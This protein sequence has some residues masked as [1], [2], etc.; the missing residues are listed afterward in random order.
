MKFNLNTAKLFVPDGLPDDKA[1]ARTT[2]MAIGA[3]P[4]D[5]E[6]MAFHG[7]LECFH[8]QKKWLTGVTVTNGSGS[9]RDGVYS[10]YTD[11]EMRA[12]RIKEQKKAAIVGE[13]AA[14]AFLDYP[15]SAVKD[16]DNKGPVNDIIELLKAAQP[17]VLFTHNLADKH[18]THVAVALRVIE[19]ARSLPADQ[20]PSRVFGCE[21]WR[22]LDWMCDK[23]KVAFECSRHENLQMALLG[24][25]DSQIAGGKRYDLATMGR[26]RAHATYH[27]AHSVDIM[28]GTT[29]AMD[30]TPL[31][32]DPSRDI[33][34][35]IKGFIDRFSE[36]V[37][38]SITKL[39]SK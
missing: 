4:D 2:H 17:E 33:A 22:D 16:P 25:F 14:H 13:Y 36:E 9:P 18:E 39:V 26:R 21:V 7:I 31:V 32:D 1:L 34:E 27:S 8:Q 38:S 10:D 29:F 15:S 20:R 30:L 24:L 19:A 28:T 5:I 11:D 12:I 35:V 6:V 3:H 37:V 23:D